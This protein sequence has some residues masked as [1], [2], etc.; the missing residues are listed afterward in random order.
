MKPQLIKPTALIMLLALSGIV[1]AQKL[2]L[3]KTHK[4]TGQAK[5]GYLDE[6]KYDETSGNTALSFITRET[7]NITGNKSKVKYQIFNFDKEYNF[8]NMDEKVDVYHNKRYKGDNYSVTGISMENNLAGTF[9]LRKKQIDYTWNWFFGGYNKKVKLLEKIKPKDDV[10]SKYSLLAKFE[11]DET[12]EVIALVRPKGKNATPNE[13]SLMKVNSELEFAITE[14]KKFDNPQVLASNILIPKVG[15]S[16]DDEGGDEEAPAEDGPEASDDQGNIA[17]NDAAF[18]FAPS[19]SGG[20]S[21]NPNSYTYWRVDATGKILETVQINAKASV[22]DINQSISAGE[23]FYIG[24]PANEGKFYD[25]TIS[26]PA[27]GPAPDL[28]NIK[29]KTYQLCKI[30]NGEVEYITLT[31]LDDFEAKLQIPPS[32]KKS[33]SYRG[34]KFHFTTAT[35][36]H[37]GSIF[38]CGQN[39]D[40]TTVNKV[41][42]KSYKDVVMFY[43]DPKGILKAQYGVH[44]EENNKYA[45]ASA[46]SQ[47]IYVGKESV[48]WSIME[49]DGVRTEQEGKVKAVKAL[50][51]PSVARIDPESG[52]I[53]DF[54]QLGLEDGK[55]KYYLHNSFPILQISSDNSMVYLGADKPGKTLWFGK[56]VME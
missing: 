23:S 5:R 46:T 50:I 52:K 45:K 47:S 49:M 3:E 26:K 13:F 56:L 24:G 31:N 33:P 53:N 40:W 8:I 41:K 51:Y 18:I 9:V 1:R 4:I 6:V 16:D 48:Y 37:D 28:E 17:S 54:V 10:G 2:T 7:T 32:Q 44:R 20:K 12:G 22:W 21:S 36:Y 34:K 39:Y 30:T 14:T 15:D 38:V 35:T 25:Q 55:P 11:N 42:Q 29:W 43:F 19:S 27:F